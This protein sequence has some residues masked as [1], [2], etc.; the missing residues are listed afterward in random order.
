MNKKLNLKANWKFCQEFRDEMIQIGYAEDEFQTVTIPHSTENVPFNYFEEKSYQKVTCYRR[1]LNI[2]AEWLDNAVFIDFEGVMCY[3]EIYVNAKYVGFHKGGFT[4]FSFNVT[5]YLVSGENLLTVKVDSNERADIP[6]SGDKMDYLCYGGIYREV[7]LR[8]NPKIYTKDVV[9]TANKLLS[10]YCDISIGVTISNLSDNDTQKDFD[11]ALVF[12]DDIVC[13]KKINKKIITGDN[14]FTTLFENIENIALWSIENPNLY[15]IKISTDK[16]EFILR[17]GFRTA[18]FTPEGFFL[19]G[20]NIKLVGLNRHQSFPYVGFAMPER[21]Q[22]KDA[23]ILKYDLNLNIVRTSHYPQSRHFHDR[24][25]EIGLLVF[26]EIPGWVYI[27]DEE[28]Q[29]NCLQNVEDMI[30]RDRNRPS[31]ILWGVRVNESGDNHDLYIKTNQLSH[32]LDSTRQTAGVRWME[33]SEFL[34][35]VYTMNDFVHQGANIALRCPKWVVGKG[36]YTPYLVSEYAG[37]MYPTK[38]GDQ[39]ER[40]VEHALRHSR[41]QNASFANTHIS[42]A[43]GWCAFDYNTHFNFGSGDR[44]C[45]HGVMDMFRNPKFA[46]FH[47]SSQKSPDKG[48]V[49]EPTT[50][51][52]FGERDV[53]WFWPLYVYTNCDYLEAFI[54]DENLGKFRPDTNQFPHLKHP[55]VVIKDIAPRAPENWKD[56]KIKGYV[57][58]QIVGEKTMSCNSVPAEL[59]V[60]SDN[61]ELF[62]DGVDTTRIVINLVDK[63][64]N[65]FP[66]LN[67]P[68]EITVTGACELIGPKLITL[69]G[70]YASIWVKSNGIVGNAAITVES[71]RKF[72]KEIEISFV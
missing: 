61:Y 18:E 64:G 45:Y 56:L 34:E 43:I 17:T 57:D 5:E 33:Q 67:E 12:N 13:S 72:S 49:I 59:K 50:T 29:K 11:V 41:I 6:P 68:L 40:K 69:M 44:I 31:V 27:G 7:F 39:E 25:D 62:A 19:N 65:V 60:I 47:Y 3:A 55:P 21:V 51:W 16:D 52:A 20:E 22:K 32:N 30:V 46:A 63:C 23:D 66:F 54:G 71:Q 70:G 58:G 9:C 37:H 4:H 1:R 28:W 35:D 26:E 53:G 48:I 42:G 24:C 2:E 10:K 38:I 15:Y 36:E 14:V 8:V